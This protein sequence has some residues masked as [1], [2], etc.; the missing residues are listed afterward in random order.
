VQINDTLPS[1][2][3]GEKERETQLKNN[4][5]GSKE[6]VSVT[7]YTDTTIPI[8]RRGR[9]I[10]TPRRGRREDKKRKRP[11]GKGVSIQGGFRLNPILIKEKRQWMTNENERWWGGGPG[12]PCL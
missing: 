8:S 1:G 5:K 9:G 10:S 12:R 3:T 7:A 4:R 11:N 6:G 2:E